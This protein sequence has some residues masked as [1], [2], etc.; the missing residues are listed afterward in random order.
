[1][2]A[3]FKQPIKELVFTLMTYMMSFKL[4]F[5]I[6]VKPG[7]LD[8]GT[9]KQV[10]ERA[11]MKVGVWVT[12]RAAENKWYVSERVKDRIKEQMAGYGYTDMKLYAKDMHEVVYQGT[13]HGKT[14]V[15]NYERA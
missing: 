9:S 8:F 1:M 3:Y 11:I 10:K 4:G 6:K 12:E 14:Q 13:Y 5:L 15:F 2:K 7:L